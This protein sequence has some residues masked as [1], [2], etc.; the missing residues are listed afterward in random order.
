MTSVVRFVII[1]SVFICVSV[2]CGLVCGIQLLFFI[3][4]TVLVSV[5]D[6]LYCDSYRICVGLFV[7]L[8]VCTINLF[9]V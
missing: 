6:H 2:V 8:T 7:L 3:A 5:C 4:L 1:V 9:L